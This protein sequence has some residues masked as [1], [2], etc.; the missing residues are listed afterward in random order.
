MLTNTSVMD[1]NQ[2]LNGDVSEHKKSKLDNYDKI[3]QKC[4]EEANN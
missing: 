1:I 3:V 4:V 2:S